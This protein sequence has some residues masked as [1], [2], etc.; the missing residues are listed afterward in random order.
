M[1][2]KRIIGEILRGNSAPTVAPPKLSIP[3]QIDNMKKKGIAFS[4]CSE[5]EARKF[6]AE[7]NYY[8]KLKSYAHNNHHKD[9]CPCHQICSSSGSRYD[10]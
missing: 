8:Y 9:L 7:H 10:G 3:K 6:L 1:V 5:S 2:E 4:I